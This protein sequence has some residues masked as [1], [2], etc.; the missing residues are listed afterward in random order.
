MKNW[1]DQNHRVVWASDLLE[2]KNSFTLDLLS[3]APDP[4]A[5]RDSNT[6]L[7]ATDLSEDSVR[8]LNRLIPFFKHLGVNLRLYHAPNGSAPSSRFATPSAA[9]GNDLA[10]LPT[11]SITD[12]WT[13]FQ[14]LEEIRNDVILNGVPCTYELDPTDGPL[15]ERILHAATR[16]DASWVAISG[17]TDLQ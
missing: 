2:A 14:K 6:V 15:M 7:F 8:I 17:F 1:L 9:S 10:A 12:A 16:A 4:T 5:R 11:R 13:S 3:N